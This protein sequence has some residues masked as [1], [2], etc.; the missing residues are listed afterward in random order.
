M[1]SSER[2]ALVL[3][4]GLAVAGHAVRLFVLRPG[5][6]PGEV[7]LLASLAPGSAAAHKDS[8][9][10]L[11]RPL[12]PGERIDL[13][14]APIA[15]IV[16]LPRV[17][18]ALAKRIVADREAHGAFGGL[19][20]LDRV[21]GIGPGLLQTLAPAVAFSGSAGR[22]A[23]EAP[24]GGG[25]CLAGFGPGTVPL[26]TAVRVCGTPPPVRPAKAGQGGLVALNSASAAELNALPG[27]GVAR[28]AA[29][30]AERERHGPFA[31]V[32]QLT[33]VPGIKS[34]LVQKLRDRLRV[35]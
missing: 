22:A 6:A 28:A 23:P 32:D 17:G 5:A 7:Q 14:R 1:G 19:P 9:I 8:T 4:L 18:T 3:M 16:R 33:R 2:R 12:E 30:V 20:G 24:A 21:A 29:I 26:D 13:D 11:A 25:V 10:A 31:S 15:E 35:P 34:A 27:I